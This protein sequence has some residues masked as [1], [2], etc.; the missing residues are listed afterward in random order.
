MT[1][2]DVDQVM[3]IE[4]GAF[5]LPWSKESYLGE[6]KNRFAHYR[7]LDI[8]G[9]VAAYG[10]VWVIFEQAHITNVAVRE[11]YRQRGMGSALLQALEQVARSRKAD[12][13]YLEVRPSN[14]A[15]V[16]MYES[17]GYGKSGARQ[18]YYTDNGEDAYI[19]SK[20]LF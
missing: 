10:G 5:S 7:V 4:Q 18:A 2:Q 17:L 6:L 20:I 12:H 3:E 15:A 14:R 8:G 13:I 16:N 11:Q 1:I 9:V 19:M